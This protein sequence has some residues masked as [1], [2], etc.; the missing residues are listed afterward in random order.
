MAI[1]ISILQ[2][3]FAIVAYAIVAYAMD[4]DTYNGGI[5]SCLAVV[6][7]VTFYV[8]HWGMVALCCLASLTLAILLF[9]DSDAS[10]AFFGA[11]ILG[12]TIGTIVS[13]LC[14]W[15]TSTTTCRPAG[16]ETCDLVA[17]NGHYATMTDELISF[18]YIDGDNVISVE[19]PREDIPVESLV[20]NSRPVVVVE[21]QV[22]QTSSFLTGEVREQ[23]AEPTYVL[24]LYTGDILF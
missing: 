2:V 11:L 17:I 5:I 15:M 6:A 3:V 10:S 20:A 7:L 23:E 18:S 4:C 1:F 8:F 9:K 14:V 22:S 24:R 21:R 13:F 19:A 12:A 16:E